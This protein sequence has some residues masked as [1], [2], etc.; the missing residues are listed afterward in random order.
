[1]EDNIIYSLRIPIRVMSQN[2]FWVNDGKGGRHISRNGKIYRKF[3]KTYIEV[4]L[5][6]KEIH[7]L[8]DSRL[9]ISYVFYCKTWRQID[10]L[11]GE[12]PL[13]D[14]LEGLLFNNDEQIDEGSVRRVYNSPFDAIQIEISILKPLDRKTKKK[15]KKI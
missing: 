10:T 2:S 14:S 11:N 1:M 15:T 6:N 9:K 13:T 4:S 8:N 5:K 3:I 7:H 12:K